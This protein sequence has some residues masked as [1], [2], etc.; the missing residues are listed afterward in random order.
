M[1]VLMLFYSINFINWNTQL[2][3]GCIH[4][5]GLSARHLTTSLVNHC[6]YKATEITPRPRNLD[7]FVR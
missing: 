1:Q 3:R 2:N 6:L 5:Y 7:E 4:G